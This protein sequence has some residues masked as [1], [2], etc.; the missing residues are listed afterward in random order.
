MFEETTLFGISMAPRAN[1]RALVVITYLATALAMLLSTVFALWIVGSGDHRI[2]KPLGFMAAWI[3]FFLVFVIIPGSGQIRGIFGGMVP[4]ELFR[5][6]PKLVQLTNLGLTPPIPGENPEGDEREIGV[7][8]R[9]CYLAFRI[10]SYYA[11][12]PFLSLTMLLGNARPDRAAKFMVVA[13]FIP[14]LIMAFTLPQAIVLWTEPD[15]PEEEPV[16]A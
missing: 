4:V 7:R 1:R 8:N 2:L 15:L 14:L 13:E 9:A 10:I 6:Q 3:P 12:F 16:R 11:F 5:P